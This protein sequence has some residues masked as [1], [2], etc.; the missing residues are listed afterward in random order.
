MALGQVISQRDKYRPRECRRRAA[1]LDLSQKPADFSVRTPRRRGM[2]IALVVAFRTANGRLQMSMGRIG[3]GLATL[4]VAA[5][6][7]SAA[8]IIGVGDPLT[9]PAL[10]GGAQQGFD[11]VAAGDYGS[12]TLGNVTYIGVGA[13]FTIDG[14]F[15][16]SFNTTG[17]QSMLNGF[18]E[19]PA[20][21]RFDFAT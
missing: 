7:A 12:L 6:T 19:L 8:P 16:G 21:F 1:R 3:L 17:G 9:N 5:T 2:P 13:P 10:T 11:A 4:L 20:A 14:S 15:N 18:D